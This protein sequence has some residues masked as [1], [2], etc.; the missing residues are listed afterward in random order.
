MS[1]LMSGGYIW[2]KLFLS[3]HLQQKQLCSPERKNN[4]TSGST[5]IDWHKLI[6]IL[7]QK[8]YLLDF[9]FLASKVRCNTMSVSTLFSTPVLNSLHLCLFWK[10]SAS[11]A[12]WAKSVSCINKPTDSPMLLHH[13]AH[14]KDGTGWGL[15]GLISDLHAL[16][17]KLGCDFD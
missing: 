8:C 9:Y 1:A 12:G 14:S 15:L 16:F 2:T 7:Q 4:S 5:E 6:S 10:Y 11:V 3:W 13:H 17:D